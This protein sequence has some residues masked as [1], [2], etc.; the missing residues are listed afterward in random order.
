MPLTELVSAPRNP[1]GHDQDGIGR[2]MSRFG[3]TAPIELDDRTGRIA[4]G[5]GRLAQLLTRKEAGQEPPEGVEVTPDGDWLAP[6][7][8]GWS[9]R[10]DAEAEAYLIAANQLTVRGGW[11][12]EA[13]LSE[14][15]A[16]V[17]ASDSGLD[18]VGFSDDDFAALLESVT[19]GDPEA[20][21]D[22]TSDRA[23]TTG[24]MLAVADVTVGEPKHDV[25]HGQVWTVGAHVLVIAR[26]LDE[27]HLWR[28]FLPERMFVPYPEP[29]ITL[30]T[31]AAATPLLLI[32]PNRYLAG[33]LLD[34]HVSVHGEDTIELQA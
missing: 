29:Y 34:K 30:S 16:T 22:S 17:A 13:L 11:E 3:F 31:I 4:S 18:G 7:V 24:E 33:H 25:A 21:P 15:L 14:M 1:K 19:A 26:L 12:D 28:H 5:H 9:S 6:V 10:D 20:D 32:Q 23:P 2:S 27:H 8:R